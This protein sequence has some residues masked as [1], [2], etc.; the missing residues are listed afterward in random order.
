[1]E[2]SLRKLRFVFVLS[3]L[4]IVLGCTPRYARY[5]S[6]KKENDI[7]RRSFEILDRIE[8]ENRGRGDFR[9]F[10][11]VRFF[12]GTPYCYGGDDR[13]GMDCSGFVVAV[14]QNVYRINLAHNTSQLFKRCRP[15]SRNYLQAGDLVFFDMNFSGRIDHVGIYLADGYFA[16]ASSSYGVVIARLE[17]N[18]YRRRLFAFGRVAP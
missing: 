1:M 7:V 16:H 9:L 18:Y 6:P 5:Q 14:Y 13:R 2:I 15:I 11:E 10:R 17:D 3:L 12:L 4:F 8:R